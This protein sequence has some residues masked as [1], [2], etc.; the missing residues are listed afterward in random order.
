MRHRFEIL[1][2]LASAVS[3]VFAF[4]AE[5][6]VRQGI[7][8]VK[9]ASEATSDG[10]ADL[11]KNGLV[12]K[13]MALYAKDGG[14][15]RYRGEYQPP[16]VSRAPVSALMIYVAPSSSSATRD[17]RSWGTA[18]TDVQT[19][20]ELASVSKAAVWIKAGE[21]RPTKRMDKIAALL[22]YDGVKI[23]GGFSGTEADPAQRPAAGA[24]T[25]L[26]AKTATGDDRYP[27]VLYGADNVLLDRLTVR[28]GDARGFTYN[29]K[30]RGLLAYHAGKTFYPLPHLVD[31]AL[32]APSEPV[33][34]TMTIKNCRFEQNDAVEGGAIYA[35]GKAS[36]RVSDSTFEG[37]RAVY[38]GAVVD[39]EGVTA[40]YSQT[41]FV[42]NE[43]TKDGGAVY[44]DYGSQV[45][46]SDVRFEDDKA[47][48][49]GGAI[50][51]ISRASQLG[52]TTAAVERSVF[53]GNEAQDGAS[54]YNLDGS[55]LTIADSTYPSN[56]VVDRAAAD[57]P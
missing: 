27:H 26:S 2:A 15:V 37:N 13:L 20:I 55:T 47:Q 38:G 21:Y 5:A 50:Y 36:L 41:S 29:G 18:L 3:L 30:G 10:G 22:L 39:R 23:Y 24:Q 25:V 57:K 34:F 49:K 17:G 12:G 16:N 48:G 33:G 11:M 1:I 43:A 35:F 56:S 40:T 52:A 4:V 46:F 42:D 53:S 6:S 9:P 19:A 44:A 45:T 54:I 28:D 7:W 32:A 8:Y 31:G 14:T 51:L